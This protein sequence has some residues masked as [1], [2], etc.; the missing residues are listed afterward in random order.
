MSML[1]RNRRVDD[2]IPTASLADIAFLRREY[3]RMIDVLDAVKLA[4]GVRI[5]LQPWDS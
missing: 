2:S 4:G 3:G 1:T 5:S